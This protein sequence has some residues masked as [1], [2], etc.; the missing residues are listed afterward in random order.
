MGLEEQNC[1]F[2]VLCLDPG[3]CFREV[4]PGRLLV[5]CIGLFRWGVRSQ[6]IP[7]LLGGCA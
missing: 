3:A 5:L 1:A 7:D 2:V 4:R 6:G